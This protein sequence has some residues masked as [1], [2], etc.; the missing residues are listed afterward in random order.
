MYQYHAMDMKVCKRRKTT[1]VPP[2]AE[3]LDEL[4]TEILLRLPVKSLLRFKSVSKAWRATISDPFFVRSHLR[5]SASRWRQNPSLL[6]T[7]HTLFHVIEGEPWPSTFSTDISFYQWQQPSSEEEES[8]AR[9]VMH[10]DDFLEEFN[11]VCYFAH[12]DGLVVAP[13]NTNVYLFNPATRDAMRLPINNRNKMY[14]YVACLPVGLGRDPRTGRHKV[15]RAFYR[16]R[17]PLTGVHDMGMEVFTV[18]VDSD[19]WREIT[20]NPLYPVSVWITPVF[21]KGAL[22][23][24]IDKPGLDPSPCGILRLSLDDE[25][26]S[27]THLPDSLDPA[28]DD[29]FILDE[30][31]GELFL[32]AFSSSE[33]LNIWT[34]VEQDTRWEHC[35]TLNISGMAH[36]VALLPG[37]GV[38]ILRASHYI[39]RYDLQTH[40]IDT[41]CE[42]DRLRYQHDGTTEEDAGSGQEIFYFNVIPYTESLVRI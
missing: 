39:S 28:L 17:D 15:V 29:S 18:G 4:L 26:F 31:H 7:P 3:L 22:F 16:S 42:L 30:V 34:L 14:Q 24:I 9:F 23:W 37:G 33:P 32:T 38:M 41:I 25:S 11:S 35:Y 8:E 10:T 27:V 21:A 19:S 40:Q 20:P 1:K 2:P 12:C 5:Q 6:V 36:P 13:T